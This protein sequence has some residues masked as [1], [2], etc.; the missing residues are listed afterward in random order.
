MVRG[1]EVDGVWFSAA[2]KEIVRGVSLRAAPGETVAVLGPSGCGKTT[3][4]RIIAGLGEPSRGRVVFDGADITTTATHRRR[5]GM[6]FQDFALFPHLRVAA[7][8]EFGLREMRL[9]ARERSKRAEALLERVGLGGY[10]K[11][12]VETLS[13][14]ERQRVALARALAPE[15]RLLMLDEPLGALDRG[16]KERLTVEL[17][18][19]L[20]ELDIPAVY[21]THDQ[22]EAFAI[23]DRLVIMRE[24]MV[25][26]EGTPEE[27]YRSPRTEF[28]ARFLGFENLVDGVVEGGRVRTAVG[29]WGMK[30][31]PPGDVLV[32]LRGDGVTLAD[33]VGEGIV[34][35]VVVGRLF[36][37]QMQRVSVASGGTV[38]RFD[39]QGG[40]K[41]PGD[42][43][44][45]FVRVP[46]VELVAR[47]AEI[48]GDVAPL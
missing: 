23:G 42:G 34:R 27:V 19:T 7:N 37:G 30:D 12:T 3:L 24:G 47:D 33:G 5:F 8:V 20:H 38:L 40:L 17:A 18:A 48:A 46:G 45:V 28:V 11:R 41:L 15:P 29:E 43:G 39:F 9:G 10:G 35:G 31:A 6:M 22:F 32:L 2:G 16:L 44:E 4:L 1:L 21:V 26:R 13:G 25:V 36:Q 14:G